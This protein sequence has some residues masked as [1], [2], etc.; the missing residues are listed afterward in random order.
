MDNNLRLS[1]LIPVFMAE[2][3]LALPV[4]IQALPFIDDGSTEGPE[5]SLRPL[6]R[7][8]P[9]YS[10]FSFQKISGNRP[11]SNPAMTTP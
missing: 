10:K 5:D 1:I 9:T 7:E 11:H 4:D 2:R 8:V 3:I 6:S